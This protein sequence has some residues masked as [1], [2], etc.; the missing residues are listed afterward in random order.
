MQRQGTSE[1]GDKGTRVKGVRNSLGRRTFAIPVGTSRRV[2][3][4]V[5][6]TVRGAFQEWEVPSVMV[7]GFDGAVWLSSRAVIG[8]S[9]PVGS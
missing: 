4:T 3:V 7:V 5:F 1:Q 6:S 2:D 9:K 8:V